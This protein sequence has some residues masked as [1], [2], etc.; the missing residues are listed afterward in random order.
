MLNTMAL[1]TGSRLRLPSCYV[2]VSNDE[3]E[4]LDGGM[5]FWT[6]VG[7]ISACIGVAVVIGA[8]IVTGTIAVVASVL[9]MTFAT[10][11]K[12]VGAAAVTKIILS[13][14]GGS[15]AAGITIAGILIGS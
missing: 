15:A 14:L 5:G 7:I 3:M 2:E 9:K 11:V 4:Y 1:E 10:Y 13:T 8:A 12:K 6:K